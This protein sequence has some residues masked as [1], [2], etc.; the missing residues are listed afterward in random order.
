MKNRWILFTGLISLILTACNTTALESG[1][2]NSLCIASDFL[3][4][5][6]TVFFKGFQK[7]KG[8][9]IYIRP[10]SA[11]SIISH[12]KAYGYNSQFDMVL[13]QSTIHL[14]Q[15]SENQLLHPITE[16][17]IL[18]HEKFIAPKNDWMVLGLDP[19]VITDTVPHRSFQYNDLT[20]GKKWKN[21]LNDDEMAMFQA[22]VLFQ[23]GRKNIQKSFSWLEKIN[24]QTATGKDSVAV[25][26]YALSRLS[27]I[28]SEKQL[29]I[30]PNQT[31][32]HGVFYDGVGVGIIR[33]SSK[34]VAATSF[35]DYYTNIVFNQKLCNNLHI[36]PLTNPNGMSKF[37]YQNDYPMLFR[38]TPR[39]AVGQIR[40]VERIRKRL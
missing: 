36:L 7:K 22:A 11:D 31:S 33:H 24:Q 18:K 9:K 19:Y 28:H 10:L 29:F 4:P 27:K 23:F 13:L 30:Y 2:P 16:S 32:N 40:N 25:A 37:S 5:A 26:S 39:L 12:F 14:H 20:Y 1:K 15:L 6:D 21:E 34:Y 38:C 35:I 8:I 17:E 3:T